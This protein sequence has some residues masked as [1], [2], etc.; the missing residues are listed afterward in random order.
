MVSIKKQNRFLLMLVVICIIII[1]LGILGAWWYVMTTSS[2]DS[3]Q[4]NDKICM[5]K[6]EYDS[7]LATKR[8]IVRV[9]HT[10]PPQVQYS[11]PSTQQTQRSDIRD[12]KVLYDP[13]Y[14]PL[15]RTESSIHNSV[16][17]AI[18]AKQLYTKT[19][20][21]TDRY[22]L[23]GYLTNND[24]N[25]DSG[26][27]TWKLMARQKDKNRS[28]FYLVPSNNNYDMKIM[29]TDDIVKGDKLRDIYT[30][31]K[32]LSFSSPLLNTTPYEVTEIPMNDFTNM[33]E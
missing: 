20:E 18:D 29:V 19:R 17:N 26:G 22:R 1:A 6:R 21:F 5:R 25:K 11:V 33:Y 10:Q 8:D 12:R 32:Q 16:V 15:N 31:P 23:V 3:I 4:A 14:P 30:I 24:Q 2:S 28:E 27:N 13:L 9:N 7:L